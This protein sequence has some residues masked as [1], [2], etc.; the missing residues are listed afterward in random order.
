MMRGEF[1]NSTVYPLSCT[2]SDVYKYNALDATVKQPMMENALTCKNNF[3]TFCAQEG[4]PNFY[5]LDI[6]NMAEELTIMPANVRFNVTPSNNISSANDF[7]LM[8]FARHGAMPSETLYDYSSDL[9]KA[10][11]V[12]RSPLIGRLYISILPVNLAK[13]FGGTQESD[14]KVCYSMESQVVQCPLGKAGPNCTM[15]SYTLQVVL[16]ARCV[17]ACIFILC[18]LSL[19]FLG[20]QNLHLRF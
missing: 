16:I 19:I 17:S 5:S 8:C 18:C 6:T 1:C 20:L 12:I 3:E 13:N 7:N 11:L 14:V 2:A 9:R 10:P 15:G 4:V